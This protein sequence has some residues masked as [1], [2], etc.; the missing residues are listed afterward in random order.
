MVFVWPF[1]WACREL[2][3]PKR[4]FPARQNDVLFLRYIVARLAAFRNVWWSMSNEW[5]Q[6]GCKWTPPDPEGAPPAAP[7]WWPPAAATPAWDTP[8]WD[9][10]FEAVRAEDPYRHLMGIHNNAYLYNGSRPWI[11]HYSVQHTHNKPQDFNRLYGRS[12]SCGTRSSTRA[13]TPRTGAA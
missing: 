10:L 13:T 4:W 3:S 11:S 1:V 9:A 7:G 12:L 8:V 6:G 5:N 2:S